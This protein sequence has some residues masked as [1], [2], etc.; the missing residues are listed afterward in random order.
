MLNNMLVWYTSDR[1]VGWWQCKEV[2]ELRAF[3]QSMVEW[4]LEE[5]DSAMLS[6]TIW[7]Q[8][9][10]KYYKLK[11]WN[12]FKWFT[13]QIVKAVTITIVI[14]TA[15]ILAIFLNFGK[16]ICLLDYLHFRLYLSQNFCGLNQ[17]LFLSKQFLMWLK[18]LFQ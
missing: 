10:D 12:F 7:L 2:Q 1:E 3:Q 16:G 13:W 17:V 6:D 15:F 4:I 18:Y 9:T 5:V 11:F 8:G 14:L